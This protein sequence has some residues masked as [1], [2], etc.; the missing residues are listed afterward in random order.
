MNNGDSPDLSALLKQA[1]QQQQATEMLRLALDNAL[2]NP[3]LVKRANLNLTH[4]I[5]E[6]DGTRLLLIA[7][8]NGERWDV[9]LSEPACRTL[10]RSLSDLAAQ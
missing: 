2:R 7:L 10:H 3:M 4:L 6:Q 9:P 8:P 1:A 5:R